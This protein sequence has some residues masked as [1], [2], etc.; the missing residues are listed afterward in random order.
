MSPLHLPKSPHGCDHPT[1]PLQCWVLWHSFLK[2][3]WNDFFATGNLSPCQLSWQP[4]L[5]CLGVRGSS[6]K[7]GGDVFFARDG[8]GFDDDALLS[9]DVHPKTMI[10]NGR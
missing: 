3:E 9:S 10:R 2:Q 8:F 7:S 6:V 1:P 4:T 5:H